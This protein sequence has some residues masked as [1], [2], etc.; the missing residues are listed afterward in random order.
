MEASYFRIKPPNSIQTALVGSSAFSTPPVYARFD[1]DN[2]LQGLPG[3]GPITVTVPV[4]HINGGNGYVI[5]H[6][7]SSYQYRIPRMMNYDLEGAA[8]LPPSSIIPRIVGSAR[9]EEVFVN[10][11]EGTT[12]QP[13]GPDGVPPIPDARGGLMADPI[14]NGPPAQSINRLAGI[15]AGVAG[16]DVGIDN[17]AADMFQNVMDGPQQLPPQVIPDQ[18]GRSIASMSGIVAGNQP[19]AEVDQPGPAPQYMSGVVHEE[20]EIENDEIAPAYRNVLGGRGDA[21]PAGEPANMAQRLR[22]RRQNRR[23]DARARIAEDARVALEVARAAHAID[24]DN[25]AEP[26]A[27]PYGAQPQAGK[28]AHNDDDDDEDYEDGNFKARKVVK[29]NKLKRK[30]ESEEYSEKF[31]KPRTEP[32][33]PSKRYLDKKKKKTGAKRFGI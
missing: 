15:P 14:L 18:P 33:T 1:A 9:D 32:R 12:T 31:K 19:A 10:V 20:P 8:R 2:I 27:P 25:F 16:R 22:N 23:A 29:P 7:V 28:R 6:G 13:T 21:P 26:P 4:K 24:D 11:H 5:Q 30:P 17:D 3:R